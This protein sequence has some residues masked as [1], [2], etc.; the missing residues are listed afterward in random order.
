MD[1]GVGVGITAVAVAMF[2]N[3]CWQ[4]A[5]TVPP[6]VTMHKRRKP[7]RFKG[8]SIVIQCNIRAENVLV[9]FIPVRAIPRMKYFWKNKKTNNTGKVE[10][11]DQAKTISHTV[12]FLITNN[13]RPNCNVRS[14]GSLITISGQK[15]SFQ[16]NVKVKMAC[17]ANTG[18][19]RG[20]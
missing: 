5:R 20:R 18:P 9:Y 3:D 15:K 4:A 14:F 17:A 2:C 16:T 1:L 11:T 10:I 8:L 12:R 7:R 19:Q 6:A 13:A